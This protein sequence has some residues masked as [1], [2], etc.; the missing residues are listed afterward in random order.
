MPFSTPPTP[1]DRGD[2]STFPSLAD[3]YLTWLSETLVPEMN[4]ALTAGIGQVS[5]TIGNASVT[6]L[7]IVPGVYAY[8]TAN[9]S[10]GG[11]TG[12]TLGHL[13]HARRTSSAGEMQLMIVEQGSG[14]T[15]GALFARA[16]TSGSWS[17]W[18]EHVHS[19][20]T[21]ILSLGTLGFGT[22]AGGTTVQAT[23]K[24]TSVTLNKNSGRIT[25]AADALAAGATVD[26]AVNNSTVSSTDTVIVSPSGFTSYRVDVF[27]V[28]GG[29]FGVAVTNRSGASKSEALNI[30]F[31]VIKGATS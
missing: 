30:N 31:D 5:S 1:P 15:A 22:G 7:S 3:A 27:T 18:L 19:A 24:S 20:S 28:A 14:L 8:I 21:A 11:P 29:S 13:V 25:M 23:S 2:P 4:A 10:S 6:D 17:S 26:F 12:V 9:G 16:R